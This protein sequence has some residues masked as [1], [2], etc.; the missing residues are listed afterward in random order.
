MNHEFPAPGGSTPRTQNSKLKTQSSKLKVW[1]RTALIRVMYTRRAAANASARRQPRDGEVQ[2]ILVIRPDHLGDLLFATPA[3]SRLRYAFPDA[4]IN[5]LAGPWGRA[6]WEDNPCLDS[7]DTLPFPGIG[8]HH[9]G[10]RLGPYALLG[11]AARRTAHE[12]Y[13]L[14]IVLRFD[15]WWGAALLWASAI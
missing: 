1:A 3:L 9:R 7:L 15:H 12:R 8:G 11:R 2:R 4:Y 5:G 10:G 14:G 13:D 6:M